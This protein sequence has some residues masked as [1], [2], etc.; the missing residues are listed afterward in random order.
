MPPPPPEAPSPVAAARGGA[1]AAAVA[2]VPALA[3]T[4]VNGLVALCLSCVGAAPAVA[5]GAGSSVGVSAGGVTGGLL[6]LLGVAAVQLRRL[7]RCYPAGPIRRQA[8]TAQVLTLLVV[9]GLSV[10]AVQWLLLPLLAPSTAGGSVPMLA[11]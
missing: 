8:A 7:H 3:V 10:A 4:A 6:V 2:A 11:G 1:L 9:A 5:A